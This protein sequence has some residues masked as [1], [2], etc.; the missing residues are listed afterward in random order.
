MEMQHHL[1]K[2]DTSLFR[3][4]CWAQVF[5]V[6]FL[7]RFPCLPQAGL[8][9]KANMHFLTLFFTFLTST[10]LA[11]PHA[12]PKPR[13]HTRRTVAPWTQSCKATEFFEDDNVT[14]PRVAYKVTVGYPY[15]IE[16]AVEGL[17]CSQSEAWFN[18]KLCKSDGN[19][20]YY[21]EFSL[22]DAKK[23]NKQMNQDLHA[24]FPKIGFNC[25]DH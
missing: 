13:I 9:R 20:N 3:S 15:R 6:S 5:F 2:L 14:K 22:K 1:S 12:I 18:S 16:A 8:H 25:P 24:L 7:A 10:T 17:M 21:L 19:N 4:T 11:L 23:L